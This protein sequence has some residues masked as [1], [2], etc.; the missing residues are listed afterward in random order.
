VKCPYCGHN[1]SR[2]IDSRETETKA[3]GSIRRRRECTAC[4]KRYTTYE[5]LER[6]G[7]T[8]VKKDGR[9]QEYDRAK[10]LRSVEVAC[11]KRPIPKEA[12]DALVDDV[13]AE[14]FRQ[15]VPEVSSRAV[16][17]LVMDRLRAL[18]DIAYIRF[19][20]VYLSFASLRE[21]Q[22]AIERIEQR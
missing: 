14:L 10:L 4:G 12:V 19:A 11:N 5:R 13:D 7:L 8:V 6:A 3:G 22:E 16:G 21:L 2:V 20:S 9:R 1:D 15:G 17:A 18:D